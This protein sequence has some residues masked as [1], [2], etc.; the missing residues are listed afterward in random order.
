MKN[1]KSIEV[2]SLPLKDVVSDIA[3]ALNVTY[4]EDCDE[5]SVKIPATLGSGY[6]RGINFVGGLGLLEYN[7]CFNHDFEIRFIVGKVHPLKFLYCREG[8]LTHFFENSKKDNFLE[9]YQNSIVAS[10]LHG[11]HILQFQ[12]NVNTIINSLEVN[13]EV[14]QSKMDCELKSLR[15]DIKTLFNDIKA[16]NEFFY[17]GFY[18]LELAD[19]FERNESIDENTFLRKILSEGTAHQIL[20]HQIYQYEE[21]LKGDNERNY[22]RKAEIVL[23]N[24]IIRDIEEDISELE[25]ID[26]MAKRVGLSTN[27]LQQGF[28][29]YFNMSVNAYIQ[30]KRLEIS[31]ELLKNTDYTIGEIADLVGLSSKSYFAKVF[32]EKYQ[33]APSDYRKKKT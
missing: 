7:C 29:Y 30:K 18:S 32:K 4:E 21:D 6:I 1:L 19:L 26:Q 31:R 14:F 27:K 25:T 17:K 8:N 23:I 33:I 16:E 3:R 20:A 15:E 22:L 12:A 28:Q 13:R 10:K 9:Q 11:G 5:Y 24:K 2:N